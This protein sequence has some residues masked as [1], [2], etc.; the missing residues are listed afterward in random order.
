MHKQSS[1]CHQFRI[2]DLQ[3]LRATPVHFVN[4]PPVCCFAEQAI[5]DLRIKYERKAEQE[6][7]QAAA[8]AKAAATNTDA[9]AKPTEDAAALEMDDPELEA[10]RQARIAALKSKSE[11]L[12]TNKGLGYGASQ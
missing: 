8:E 1:V 5:E 6:A 9:P 10:M 12:K 3:R 7:R 11:K 4:P 2:S